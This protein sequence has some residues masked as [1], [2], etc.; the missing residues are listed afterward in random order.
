MR[1]LVLTCGAQM[2]RHQLVLSSVDILLA[3]VAAAAWLTS[4][5][6]CHVD[7]VRRGPLSQLLGSMSFIPVVTEQAWSVKR[8]SCTHTQVFVSADLRIL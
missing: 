2:L 7:A 1:P 8:A 3:F 5:T 6:S 4:F